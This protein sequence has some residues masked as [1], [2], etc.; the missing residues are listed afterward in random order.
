ML[1]KSYYSIDI[2][3]Y[4][5]CN[6]C[7]QDYTGENWCNICNS[8]RFQIEF[9]K[10]TSGDVEIDW[11]IQQTQ[12]N[13]NNCEEVIE[14]IPFDRFDGFEYLTKGSF[15][16]IYKAEWRDGYIESWN[17]ILKTWRRISYS[18][19]YVCLKSLDT[20]DKNLFLQK[21]YL[22]KVKLQ[23]YFYVIVG[24]A[25]IHELGLMHTDL[26]SGNIVCQ[27]IV[28]SY[29]TDFGLC[30]PVS[31]DNREKIHGVIPFMAPETLIRGEYTQKSDIYS[32]GMV[33][34]EVFTSYPPYYNIPH[35]KNLIMD[36][37]NGC[38]PEIKCE[39]PQL[40]KDIM[41]KCWNTDPL[42]R[43]TAKELEMRLRKYLEVDYSR[44][45]LKKQIEAI[46]KAN[47]NFIQ[48]NPKT[49]HPQAI[50][51]SRQVPIS[52]LM[53]VEPNSHELIS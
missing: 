26:H 21:I 24:L 5:K 36:I 42:N 47:I 49:T 16:E 25:K 45:W 9:G 17:H 6:E 20:L 1:Q 18:Y 53:I 4:G 23:I 14:W 10:W 13:A 32:F 43:P 3:E 22:G 44:H 48:Y 40:L 52:K 51:T 39:I 2:K 7:Q 11:F 37:C 30:K 34:L 27:D 8:R 19:A 28:K 33:M 31:K 35:D 29:I 12:L 46:D 41:E 15:G 50:Y 38:E